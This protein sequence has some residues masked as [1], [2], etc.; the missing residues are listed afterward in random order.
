MSELPSG[1]VTFVFTDVEGSTEV[2][3][4]LG[5]RYPD[6]LD[7]H[8]KLLRSTLTASGGVEVKSDGDSFFFVFSDAGSAVHGCAAAQRGLLAHDWPPDSA[9]SVRMG[10]HS[11][12]A[13][14]VGRDY[15]ALDVH[16]AARVSAAAHG[17]QVLV[18]GATAAAA[19][20]V[21]GVVFQSLGLFRL[22]GFA[23]PSALYQV[24]APDLPLSFPAPNA[25]PALH[26]NIPSRRLP[27]VGREDDV[28]AVTRLLNTASLLTLVGP[29][30]VGKTTVALELAE[31]VALAYPGGVWLV[32]LTVVSDPSRLLPALAAAI[33]VRE[34]SSSL[35]TSIEDRLAS[36]PT[37]LVLDNCEHL[38]EDCARLVTHLLARCPPLRVLATSRERLAVAGERV[39]RVD[40]LA[41]PG[42][43]AETLS[44]ILQSPAARLLC[45]RAAHL[46]PAFTPSDDDAPFIGAICR[47]LDGLPLGL[48]LAAARLPLLGAERLADLLEERLSVLESPGRHLPSHHRTLRG[49]VAWSY[50]LL[51][52]TEGRCLRYLSVFSGGCTL[53]AAAEVGGDVQERDAVVRAILSLGDKSL[54]H[55]TTSSGGT[56]LRLLETVREFARDEM[57]ALGETA[58]VEERHTA[59][60]L[61]L[62]TPPGPAPRD[63]SEGEA[64]IE[65]V[66]PEVENLRSALERCLAIGRRDLAASFAL[67]VGAI[68]AHDG[69]L[70][71]SAPALEIAAEAS[72][73]GT[74]ELADALQRL[75]HVYNGQGRMDD[76]ARVAERA[77]TEARAIGDHVLKS[78]AL[79]RAGYV[80]AGTQQWSDARRF[81]TEALMEA[82]QCEDAETQCDALLLLGMLDE[83]EGDHAKQ[84]EWNE[85][86]VAVA[87]AA[88][89]P[90]LLVRSLVNLGTA[91]AHQELFNSATELFNEAVPL[92]ERHGVPQ[93]GLFA[94][95][96]LAYIASLRG[97]LVTARDLAE[98]ALDLAQA[99]GEPR[100]EALTLNSLA[101]VAFAQGDVAEAAALLGKSLDIGVHLRDGERISYCLDALAG[102]A[103]R[104]GNMARTVRL[105]GFA[106]R[107]RGEVGFGLSDA[108]A[109]KNEV[110]ALD[111]REWLGVARYSME[112]ESGLG[113][114]LT[115]AV[116]EAREEVRDQTE[117]DA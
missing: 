102:I 30:G 49:L 42:N 46:D 103:A 6:V 64:W 73:P 12:H 66:R 22:K 27:V 107:Y 36:Q 72:R 53:D 43:E 23:E 45:E 61:R 80:A 100:A 47:R 67:A 68:T 7:G 4:R 19:E 10:A 84:A 44:S 18:T 104:R 14:P 70:S 9:I 51:N 39:R 105:L 89:A 115:N 83:Y 25:T 110:L 21:A 97:D 93:H 20:S 2:F 40:P 52:E 8:N 37:L 32:E 13:T 71:E 75:A 108:Y 116:A 50:E 62:I 33:G 92:S 59:A 112:Y 55:F 85:R 81:A 99:I 74:A 101:E 96:N 58:H 117:V 95:N 106:E 1:E 90:R 98:Q 15:I 16:L 3:A 77:L 109:T 56:R 38:A 48:E 114:S 11:G 78:A 113:M 87:R 69:K 31:Q 34:T 111:A 86:A 29:G 41:M 60:C 35:M 88:P 57:S 94:L 24:T 54:V 76:A 65:L 79:A 5:D 91:L 28:A 17:G 26:H 63:S 82:E